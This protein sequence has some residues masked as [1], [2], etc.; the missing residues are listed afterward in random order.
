MG[1]GGYSQ[2]GGFDKGATRRAG[3]HT[4]SKSE[5]ENCAALLGL[6]ESV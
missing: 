4:L 5:V 1:F 2:N 6:M 3:C